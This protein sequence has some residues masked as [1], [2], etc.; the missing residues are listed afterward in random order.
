MNRMLVVYY[1]VSNGN[2]RDI[3]HRVAEY[4]G[5]DL[6]EIRTVQ[7]YEGTYQEIVAQGKREVERGYHP[8]ILPLPL[9]VEDY[10]V[11]AI[12]T[13]TWW[14]T[15]AP[16]VAAFLSLHEWAGKTVVPFQTHGGWPG[17]TLKDIKAACEGAKF[18]CEEK[19]QFDSSGGSQ[20]ITDKNDVEQWLQ[21][22][23]KE[24]KNK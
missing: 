20:M 6:A 19:I 16:A 4:M 24:V 1:S 3:A 22:I 15:M 18:C 17:H 9:R 13:P 21:K 8:P 23:K 12:G 5:A 2:T 10:D 14:Y 11:V 7:P